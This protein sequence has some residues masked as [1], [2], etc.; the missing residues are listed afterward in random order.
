LS[1]NRARRSRSRLFSSEVIWADGMR[2]ENASS[3]PETRAPSE[4]Y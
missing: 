4:A 1:R 2:V 3:Y